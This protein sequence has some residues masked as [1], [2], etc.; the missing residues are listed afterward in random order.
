MCRHVGHVGYGDFPGRWEKQVEWNRV[1]SFQS[2]NALS[3]NLNYV[4][5]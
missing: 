2:V 4:N 1:A 3:M 5:L